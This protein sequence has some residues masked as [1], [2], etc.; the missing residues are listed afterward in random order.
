MALLAELTVAAPQTFN[1]VFAGIRRCPDIELNFDPRRGIWKKHASNCK[2]CSA[3]EC[4]DAT[5]AMDQLDMNK[6][7]EAFLFHEHHIQDERGEWKSVPIKLKSA[8]R[9]RFRQLACAKFGEF[10]F[11]N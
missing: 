8:C 4:F 10:F 1:W 11:I 5:C 9:Q 2:A 6:V 7:I 3:E